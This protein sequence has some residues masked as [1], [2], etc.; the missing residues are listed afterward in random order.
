M[1]ARPD[2]ADADIMDERRE[3]QAQQAPG[4]SGHRVLPMDGGHLADRLEK[5]G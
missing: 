5:V 1:Q 3:Q 4:S 2:A